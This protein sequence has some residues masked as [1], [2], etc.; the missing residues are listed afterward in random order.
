MKQ[1]ILISRQENGALSMIVQ[2]EVMM[3]EMKLSMAK[4]I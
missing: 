2:V 4:K 1:V 3:Q